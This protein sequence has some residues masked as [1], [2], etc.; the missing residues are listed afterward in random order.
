MKKSI[1]KL[2]TVLNK[3]EQKSVNGGVYYRCPGSSNPSNQ[4]LPPCPA[5]CIEGHCLF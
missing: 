4:T 2:G 3:T 1:L 5:F